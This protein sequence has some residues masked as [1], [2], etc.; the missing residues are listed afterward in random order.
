M[1]RFYQRQL[2]NRPLTDQSLFSRIDYLYFRPYL[3]LS[4]VNKEVAR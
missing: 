1:V 4:L 2:F 3:V